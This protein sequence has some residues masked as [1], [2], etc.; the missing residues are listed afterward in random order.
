MHIALPINRPHLV[1]QHK[2]RT[3]MLIGISPNITPLHSFLTVDEA[4][5]VL[6]CHPAQKIRLKTPLLTFYNETLEHPVFRVFCS[7]EIVQI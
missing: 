2:G 4:D 5:P 6:S 3:T 7:F 1:F